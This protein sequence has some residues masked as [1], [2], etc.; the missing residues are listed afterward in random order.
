MLSASWG[1][2]VIEG[3]VVT[4]YVFAVVAYP[5]AVAFKAIFTS[6]FVARVVTSPTRTGQ[7]AE[8]LRGTVCEISCSSSAQP[9]KMPASASIPVMPLL[10]KRSIFI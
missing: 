4:R 7:V 8:I 10:N 6:V 3:D 1:A 2:N 9:H 5:P